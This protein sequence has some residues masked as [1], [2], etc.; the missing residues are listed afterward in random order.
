MIA[1]AEGR[2]P[3]LRPRALWGNAD[4]LLLW[5]GQ[6]VSTLGSTMSQLALP[7]LALAL[8]HAPAQVGLIAAVQ[9]LPY[10]AFG[11]LAG[12]L[13]DRWD[14]KR[15][16]ICCDL[17]RALAYGSI[18][19]AYA[20]GQV[21]LALLCG[22][23]LVSGTALVFFDLAQVAALPRVVPGAQLP[24]A[25]ALNASAGS[26]ATVIGPGLAGFV[27]GLAHGAAPGAALAFLLDSLS[28]LVSVASLACIRMPF[29]AGRAPAAGRALR[30]EITEG[31]RFL[32]AAPRLR[33]IAL[34][35]LGLFF[36]TGP[37]YLAVIVLAR[38]VLHADAR[39]LGLIF[40]VS[41]VGG[42]AGAA[43]APWLAARLR[44]GQLIMGSVALWALAT[45]LLAVAVSPAM[46]V[47]GQALDSFL[48]STF[49]VAVISHR[50]A[51]TPDA[52]QGRVNG[53]ARVLALA[54][55]P[56]GTALGGLLLGP[57]GP[58]AELG[59]VALGIGLSALAASAAGLRRS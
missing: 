49:S 13:V 41:G 38:E 22:V 24:R 5:G 31:L 30:A 54:G 53:V 42:L 27:I 18:P 25:N 6:A 3:A 35:T 32:W 7:L 16:M 37:V 20:L 56:A 15:L 14:R 39:A 17:A 50:L 21:S 33:A 11:L 36:F 45:A 8:T 51:L 44:V 57:L 23:A 19:V 28:Y 52:L 26:A 29:Q 2:A 1:A 4:F 10:L 47:A 12:A 40:G 34:L 46:V 48:A 55:L 9:P 43:V 59:L 58:R